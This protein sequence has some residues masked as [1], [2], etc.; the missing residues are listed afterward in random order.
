MLCNIAHSNIS[1]DQTKIA[2]SVY[3]SF[4]RKNKYKSNGYVVKKYILMV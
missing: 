4:N 2:L 3:Q 1:N